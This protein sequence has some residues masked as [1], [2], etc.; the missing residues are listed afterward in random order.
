MG[1]EPTKKFRKKRSFK[2]AKPQ[3]DPRIFVI[4]CEGAKREK[5][6]FETLVKENQRIKVE[7]LAPLKGEPEKSAPQWVLDRAVRYVDEFGLSKYDMLWFVMDIDRWESEIL[8][9]IAKECKEKEN[10]HIVLSNP[11]FEIWL[12][13]HIDDISNSTS[14]TCKDLKQELH[15]KIEGGYKVEVFVEKIDDAIKR[16]KATD[17][18]IKSFLPKPM[19]TKLYQLA[20]A[21]QEFL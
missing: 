12:F 10:W 17:S 6:Y 3:L 14:A 7:V 13:M 21:I 8:H 15:D 11:C 1:K 20:E 2:R 16:A 18:D 4:A 19:E 9:F 5:I